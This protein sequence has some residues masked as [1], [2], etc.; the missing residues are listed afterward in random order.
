[1]SRLALTL[2]PQG[3]AL[4]LSARPCELGFEFAPVLRGEPGPPGDG[5]GGALEPADIGA[6]AVS[7]RLAEFDTPQAQA[8]ARA[9]LGL[10]TIDGGSF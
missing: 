10:Q 3:A 2:R 8:D 6:L 9:N 7:L 1:M 5:S 4:N